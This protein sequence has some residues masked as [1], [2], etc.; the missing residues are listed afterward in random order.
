MPRVKGKEQL[1]S[2]KQKD[3]RSIQGFGEYTLF[4]RFTDIENV[5]NNKVDE[6]YRHF[7]A[8]PIIEGD[9]TTWFSKPYNETPR[10]FS[11]LKTKRKI[12]M[13]Q[14]KMTQLLIIKKSLIL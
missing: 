10:L 1:C 4:E 8:E 2:C 6:K 3:F 11:D 13:V 7:L 14:S 12:V 5:V 9:T